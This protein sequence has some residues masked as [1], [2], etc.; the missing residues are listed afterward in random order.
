MKTHFP[1]ALA[2]AIL[3]G[4]IPASANF[5]INL[6]GYWPFDND[7]QDNSSTGGLGT[8]L[9]TNTTAAYV[10]GKFGEAV[11][12]DGIDQ[13]VEIL[14]VPEDTYDFPSSD[15]TISL[16]CSTPGFNKAFNTV[17]GKGEGGGPRI[18]RKAS[19]AYMYYAGGSGTGDIEGT[20][21]IQDG[22]MH[23]FVA[24]TQNGVITELWID[25]VKES[26]SG[27]DTPTIENRANPLMIGGN[28]DAGPGYRTWIGAI[29]EVAVWDRLLSDTEIGQ[30]WNG[31]TG[32]TIS[33]LIATPPVTWQ[34]QDIGSPA[35]AGSASGLGGAWT[36]TGGGTD[37]WG[38]SDQF[39]YVHQPLIGDGT[40]VTCVSSLDASDPWAKTGVMIRESL[41][42]DSKNAAVFVTPGNGV[43]FQRRTT[44]GGNTTN[45]SD[46]TGAAPHWV[47]LDREGD[48]FTGY[49]SVDGTSWTL[50]GTETISMTDPIYI[51]L[52]VTSHNAGALTTSE[53]KD[54]NVSALQA[55][56]N[57]PQPPLVLSTDGFVPL[58][59]GSDL[60]NWYTYLNGLGADT[61]PNGIFKVA[62]EQIHLLDLPQ[63]GAEAPSQPFGYFATDDDYR[64]YRLRF[65]YKWGTKKYNPRAN[66]LR[67]SGLL[68]H[69]INNDVVWPT[70]VEC[71]VQETDTGDFYML[72]GTKGDFTV[73]A[74]GNNTYQPGGFQLFNSGSSINQS[75]QYDS[76]T[77]WN[78]VEAIVTEDEGIHV[79][80]GQVNNR[81]TNYT[82]NG[83][84]LAEGKI[85]L[86]VEGAEVFYQNIEVQPLFSTGGGPDYKVL[87]FSKTAGFRHGSIPAGIA[88]VEELGVR[89]GFEVDAT[90]DAT[91]F[92]T[93]N[94]EQYACV[95][96][97]NT[98]GDVLDAAQ[99]T[100]F[101]QYMN[102]GGG[103]VGIHSATDTEYDWT[104]YGNMVGA[105][106]DGHPAVQGATINCPDC[107]HPSTSS[108]DTVWNRVDEWYNFDPDPA[109]NPDIR[110]LLE[111]DETSYSGGT[112]GTSHPISWCQDFEDTVASQKWRS[113]YTGM[114]HTSETFAE[115]MFLFHLLGGIEWAAGK[116]REPIRDMTILFDGTD[117]SNWSKLGGGAVGWQ[118]VDENNN[119]IGDYDDSM[120]IVPGQGNIVTNQSFED[121]RLHLEFR[122]NSTAP[123]TPEQNA[124]NSGLFLQSHYE[125]QVLDSFGI[126][127]DGLNDCGAIYNVRNA[128][129][130]QALPADAWQHYDIWFRAARY[131]GGVKTENARVTVF[132]NGIRIHDNVEIPGTTA[133]GQPE[134]AP[135][136]DGPASGP[137]MLQDHDANSRV[138]FRNI[139]IEPDAVLPPVLNPWIKVNDISYNAA[140]QEVTLQ[141][142]SNLTGPFTILAGGAA[143][144]IAL[145][146]PGTGLFPIVA[147]TGVSSPTTFIVPAALQ[148]DSKAFFQV[149]GN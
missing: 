138:R 32:A 44:T 90:E 49:R 85:S 113:W 72:G 14:A 64:N 40:I 23:H 52:A 122:P 35:L 27:T 115:P 21:N 91:A 132:W 36:I 105:Y 149:T 120:E 108:L 98:T 135:A 31:G 139:W 18:A 137:L 47:R 11:S 61:D 60:T 119:G 71:Q 53:M 92:T 87:V 80:N 57:P 81:G 50:L 5:D 25:G 117:F 42:A 77:E 4:S 34:N 116:S 22:Q 19:T 39:H 54:V 141:W 101:E 45:S 73:I 12:L 30:I 76:L 48:T 111:L 33:S 89:N 70:C 133:A 131:A 102:E 8:L 124:G 134:M 38:N 74:Q 15:L 84:V 66:A 68:Y 59:N 24:T 107:A 97:L 99:E 121:F 16:W 140:S 129:T 88:A 127:L 136:A 104:Y 125:I 118:L 13:R 93:N 83:Q 144:L 2:A 46:S 109:D 86:Q 94:L 62:N 82:W 78:T 114:G 112:M 145:Q 100:A 65:Q 55:P 20:S 1:I 63:F 29:D 126:S 26:D 128:D 75:A 96:F 142:S 69:Q 130:N 123:G 9:G 106:F 28:P 7:L 37:I 43:R 41:D 51:G 6:V 110:I 146:N 79:V 56:P 10:A 103:Y 3:A 95:I 143:D 67:D 58:F 148:S 147:A 17:L